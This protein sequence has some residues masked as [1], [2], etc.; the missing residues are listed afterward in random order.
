MLSQLQQQFMS[1]FQETT[2]STLIFNNN[3]TT[4]IEPSGSQQQQ[5][6]F[7]SAANAGQ[8]LA[9]FAA[10]ANGQSGKFKNRILIIFIF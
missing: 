4:L 3:P 7:F 8:T 9:L 6:T 5:Q 1:N 2:N 10:A